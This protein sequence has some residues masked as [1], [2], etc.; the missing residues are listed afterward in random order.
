MG[1]RHWGASPGQPFSNWVWQ[2]INFSVSG[3]HLQNAAVADLGNMTYTTYNCTGSRY[4]VTTNAVLYQHGMTLPGN[5]A[6]TVG[7]QGQVF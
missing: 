1:A 2:N 5:A 6:G 4:S 7:S 3:H